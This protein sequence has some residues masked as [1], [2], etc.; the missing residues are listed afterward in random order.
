MVSIIII[1]ND[2]DNEMKRVQLTIEEIN[3][4][5][6]CIKGLAEAT[7]PEA[8]N[9]LAEIL[10]APLGVI[11]PPFGNIYL[12][13]KEGQKQEEKENEIRRL[14]EEFNKLKTD[15]NKKIALKQIEETCEKYLDDINKDHYLSTEIY[16]VDVVTITLRNDEFIQECMD[17]I[18]NLIN[19]QESSVYQYADNTFFMKEKIIMNLLE[20]QK[21]G[22]LQELIDEVTEA[23]D[24]E[25][26]T[27]WN[28]SVIKSI[29]FD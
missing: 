17:V 19:D 8:L 5:K 25:C 22:G 2:K 4:R 29:H 28:R 26:Q 7:V 14:S 1:E 12:N 18:D 9:I 20:P 21:R 6:K 13:F 15:E 24:G 27:A 10:A 3:R 23:I 16:T 11:I